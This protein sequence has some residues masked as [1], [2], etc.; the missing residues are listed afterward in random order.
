MSRTYVTMG[1]TEDC[2]WSLFNQQ[3]CLVTAYNCQKVSG[4]GQPIQL[5][6]VSC[7][8]LGMI[9]QIQ[10]NH[11]LDFGSDWLENSEVNLFPQD[12]WLTLELELQQATSYES[13]AR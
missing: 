7:D 6:T 2:F 1:P 8:S 13:K 9:L 10:E 11:F 12:C 5:V 3:T 4:N